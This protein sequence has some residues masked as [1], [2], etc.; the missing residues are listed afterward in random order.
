MLSSEFAQE[1]IETPLVEEMRKSYLDYAMSVIVGRA[2]PDA[3]DGLK[4]VHRRVMHSMNE[5][6]NAW[7]RAYKKS[8]RVVGDT[9]GKYHPHGDTAVYDTMVRM[10]Q[11]FSL[12]YPLIDGQGNF[13]SIDGDNAAAMRYTEV[14]LSK[15]A[16]QLLTDLEKETV[17]F[18]PNYDGSEREPLVLPTRLPN[19][20][21]N[22]SE[23]IAVGMA[24]KIPPHN[25]REIVDGCLALLENAN[26]SIEDLIKI[27]PAPDFPTGGLIC[28]LA[29]ASDAYRTGRGSVVIRAKTH[30]EELERSGRTAI[31]VDELPY[32][33][34][35]KT[36][37]E[38]IAALVMEKKIEGVAHIQDESDKSGIRLVIEA[39][40]GENPDVLLNQLFKHTD[41]QTSFGMN[42]VA[43][44]DGQPKL[45]GLKEALE[46]F[47]SHRREIVVRRT[48]FELREARTRGHVLEGYA[49]ALSNMDE[50]VETIKASQDAAA[51]KEALLGK[52]WGSSLVADMLK[53]SKSGPS[54]TKPEDADPDVGM[55]EAKGGY[56]LSPAQAQEILQMRLQRLTGLE[57][58]KIFGEYGEVLSKID[59]LNDIL[60]NPPRVSAIIKEELASVRSE[61]GDE[62]RSQI[63]F[64]AVDI[65]NEDL[66][67][68]R[69]M[70]VSLSRVGYVK[71][72][73]ASGYSAQHRGGRGK[74]AA[75][76]KENDAATRI[77]SMNSHDTM[78]CFT[79]KG[80]CLPIK[81][82][83]LP[84]GGGNSRGRPLVNYLPLAAGESLADVI[85]MPNKESEEKFF[86][87]ATKKAIVKRT[88]IDAFRNIRAGGLIA[89]DVDEDDALLA[90]APTS[91]A[92]DVMLFASGNNAN[93]FAENELRE[94]SRT[95]RGVRG[96]RLRDEDVLIGMITTKSDDEQILIVTDLGYAK[97]TSVGAFRKASRGAIGVRAIPAREKI[98]ALTKALL[99]EEDQD[100]FAITSAGVMIR[101]KAEAIRQSS[102]S[103]QGVKMVRLG[104]DQTVSDAVAFSLPEDEEEPTEANAAED[105]EEGFGDE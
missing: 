90:V 92:Q 67:P 84:E 41:L 1:I 82:Y 53:Q 59:D 12:R 16:H 87:F 38:K 9:I 79:T 97:R 50:I 48:I 11:E 94:L 49:V 74:S 65:D 104:A 81:V 22:G 15:L 44:V 58:S 73:P 17:D 96:M 46:I 43:L 83:S 64:D 66:I 42:M 24:T 32:Q 88:P 60:A 51:A 20:L 36:L 33:V 18:G 52:R 40:R 45:L 70:I 27:I 80:R 25:L 61:F 5:L 30:F 63:T 98:G 93:R 89:I 35:K 95:A 6:G 62:R 85:P 78:L 13:G 26:L 91:G 47:L 55:D 76:L 31:I 28:G 21:L 8:A 37:Q 75:D 19:L 71:Q 86:V 102:R 77:F 3:R 103:A 56:Q 39:K 68:R 23:G 34:N 101:I 57:K 7:N 100:V 4:P 99:V 29:G 10:A 14:R 54:A 105:A 69:E 72:Q 2:L